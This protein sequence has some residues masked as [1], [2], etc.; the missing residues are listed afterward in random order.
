MYDI[1]QNKN[2]KEFISNF[3]EQIVYWVNNSK[4][5]ISESSDDILSSLEVFYTEDLF[6][7]NND[8]TK[9]LKNIFLGVYTKNPNLKI[10]YLLLLYTY[11]EEIIRY[12]QKTLSV[13]MFVEYDRS[14]ADLVKTFFK[15]FH[16]I[17][18]SMNSDEIY[19]ILYPMYIMTT[20]FN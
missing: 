8:I 18:T 19:S 2:V 10:N 12:N 20:I 14:L 3:S 1:V 4:F 5:E 6:D 7:L 15:M 17:K 13:P 11:I 16:D 9:M